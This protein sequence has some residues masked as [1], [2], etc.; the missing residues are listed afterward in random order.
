M[1]TLFQV[2]LADGSDDFE[3]KQDI[4]NAKYNF[5]DGHGTIPTKEAKEISRIMGLEETP[6]AFQV[7]NSFSF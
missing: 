7:K 1:L 2:N 4:K 6:S 3:H 5:S